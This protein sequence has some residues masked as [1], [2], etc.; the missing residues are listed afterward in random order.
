MRAAIAKGRLRS[1]FLF[2]LQLED[3]SQVLNHSG[4]HVQREEPAQARHN[5]GASLHLI[6]CPGPACRRGWDRGAFESGQPGR[7]R[8]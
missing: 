8:I 4:I 7:L 2:F 3:G 6:H 5:Q 1:Y